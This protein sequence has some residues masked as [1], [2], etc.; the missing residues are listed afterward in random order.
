M[1]TYA[2]NETGVVPANDYSTILQVVAGT[3]P[4]RIIEFSISFDG[5]DAAMIPITVELARQST[6]GTSSA[7]T[8]VEDN[9]TLEAPLA[10]GRTTFTAEPTFV[11]A[12]RHWQITPAGGLFAMQWPLGREIVVPPTE[13]LGVICYTDPGATAEV[14]ATLAFEE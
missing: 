7:A 4:L 14:Y 2:I 6:A 9:P 8:L 1:A 12:V 11:N 10:T 13:R 5:V 3:K